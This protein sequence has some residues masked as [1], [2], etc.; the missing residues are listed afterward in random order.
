MALRGA[1]GGQ[2]EGLLGVRETD[3]GLCDAAV[4]GDG[5]VRAL[6][7]GPNALDKGFFVDVLALESPVGF[8]D[9]GRVEAG[10]ADEQSPLHAR[11]PLDDLLQGDGVQ[12]LAVA[13]NDHVVKSAVVFPQVRVLGVSGEEVVGAVLGAVWEGVEDAMNSATV[14]AAGDDKL[15]HIV[16]DMSHVYSVG[17]VPVEVAP[18]ICALGHERGDQAHFAGSDDSDDLGQ[19]GQ[20]IADFRGERG[21][22]EVDIFEGAECGAGS[23]DV[24]HVFEKGRG[25]HGGRGLGGGDDGGEE[26]GGERLVG[27]NDKGDVV[28]EGFGEGEQTHKVEEGGGGEDEGVGLEVVEHGG[29]AGLGTRNVCAVVEGGEEAVRQGDGFRHAYNC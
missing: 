1:L 18:H 20:I 3:P 12:F 6:H 5:F 26:V 29:L 24:G 21:A 9:E 25:Q 16:A 13:E 27:E 10:L 28:E 22:S 15:I 4:F 2:L 19:L 23:W 8:D 7:G 11:V 17:G 14:C